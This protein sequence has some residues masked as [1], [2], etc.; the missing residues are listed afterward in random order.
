MEPITSL[1][2]VISRLKQKV[3]SMMDT[4]NASTVASSRPAC[5]IALSRAYLIVIPGHPSQLTAL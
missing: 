4:G 5:S 1:D 3:K 2:P